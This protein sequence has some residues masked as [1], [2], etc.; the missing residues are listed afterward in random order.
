MIPFRS[1]DDISLMRHHLPAIFQVRSSSDGEIDTRGPL[2][3]T[4]VV[5]CWKLHLRRVAGGS[6]MTTTL[7]FSLIAAHLMGNDL[8]ASHFSHVE[9]QEVG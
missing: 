6:M 8:D 1:A 9:A 3:L 5:A 4:I 7:A 2:T